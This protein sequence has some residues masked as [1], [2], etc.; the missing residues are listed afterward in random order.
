MLRMHDDWRITAM[1]VVVS[2]LQW[3]TR[4]DVEKLYPLSAITIKDDYAIGHTK[5]QVGPTM[6][7]IL[8]IFLFPCGAGLCGAL[9]KSHGGAGSVNIRQDVTSPH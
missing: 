7:R 8:F 9:L 6:L 3:F 2:G 1:Y 4:C 5:E